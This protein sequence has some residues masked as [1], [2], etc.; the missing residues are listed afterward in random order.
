MQA[1][2]QTCLHPIIN[3]WIEP[4][5][6]PAFFSSITS[7]TQILLTILN[8]RSV[9]T[10]VILY[11]LSFQLYISQC[12]FL[13]SYFY[14]LYW[15]FSL[16]FVLFVILKWKQAS[17]ERRLNTKL[18]SWKRS[19]IFIHTLKIMKL[20]KQLYSVSQIRFSRL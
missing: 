15:T 6:A 8:K 16:L 13:I 4:S 11:F 18:E 20:H 12:D 9:A 1:R 7:F 19:E 3:Q 5:P 14:F 17:T 10:S 2:I